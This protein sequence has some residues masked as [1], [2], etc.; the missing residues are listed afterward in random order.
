MD[1]IHS[2]INTEAQRW[3]SVSR[4]LQLTC[5]LALP[6]L[7]QAQFNFTTNDDGTATITGYTGSGGTVTIPATLNGLSV[8]GIGDGALATC[9]SLTNLTI[10]N[11]ITRIGDGAFASCTNLASVTIPDSVTSIGGEAFTACL[12]LTSVAIPNSVTNIGDWA[13]TDCTALTAID[14]DP[15]NPVYSSIAGVLFDQ[16]QDTLVSYPGGLPGS[17]AI[18]NSVTSIQKYAF[19]TCT[20]LS[21]VTIPDSVTNVGDYAFYICTSLAGLTLPSSLTSIGN[22]TFGHCTSL[23]NVAIPNSVT[24]LGNYAFEYCISL[25]SVAIPSSTT[26]LGGNLFMGCTSLTEIDVDPSNPT[27][28]SFAGVLFDKG[29]TTLIEYPGGQAGSYTIPNGVASIGPGA[30]SDCTNLTSVTI[31]ESVTTIGDDA[32]EYCF[33]LTSLAIPDLLTNLGDYAFA[34]CDSLT[35]STM[36]NSVASIGE[37]AFYD[38]TNLASVIIPSSVISLGGS[39]FEGCDDLMAVFFQGNA[40]TPENDSTVF[41]SDATNLAAYYL[42]GTTGWGLIFDDLP[43]V[44]LTES[45]TVNTTT[46]TTPLLV[47]FQASGVDSAGNAITNWSW[48]FGDGAS[49]SAPNPAHTYTTAGTFSPAL[50][51]TNNLGLMVLG[52]GTQITTLA[53][54]ASTDFIYTTNNGAITITGYTGPGGSVLIPSTIDDLTVTSIGASAFYDSALLLSVTIPDSVTNIADG[55]FFECESLTNVTIG[56]GVISLGDEAFGGCTGLTNVTIPT[57]IVSIG[58]EAFEDCLGLTSVTIPNSV[59]NVGETPFYNCTSLIEID[60]D[61]G[62]PVYVSIAGVLLDQ[63]QTTLLEYPSGQVGSYTIPSTV[64]CIGDQA[65]EGCT[66]LTNVTFP[67]GVTT[68]GNYSFAYCSNLTSVVFPPTS[69]TNLGNYA[70]AYCT[71]LKSLDLPASLTT[72]NTVATNSGGGRLGDYDFAYCSGLDAIYYPGDPPSSETIFADDNAVVY[73]PAA[74]A[75]WGAELFGMPTVELNPPAVPAAVYFIRADGMS[76]QINVSDLLT[77][78]TLAQGDAISLVGAGTDGLNRLS[79]NGTTLTINDTYLLYTN[80]VIPD[81][82]DSFNFTVSDALGQTAV[83]TVLIVMDRNVIGQASPN[84][85][86]TPSNVIANFSGVPTFP[87]TVERSTNLMQGAGWVAICTNP[88]STNGLFQ[89]LDRFQDLSNSVPL[90]PASAYY[91]LRYNP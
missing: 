49:S 56:H 43:A 1:G 80:S 65:F 14:V 59:T 31:S 18:P 89:V 46:G 44:M 78:V 8:T 66:T 6:A 10:S 71:S 51:A 75:G 33:G 42:A 36:G 34:Y 85:T 4:L 74:A 41:Q 28:S 20:T 50:I 16:A 26:T 27:Y 53:P 81:V 37:Y 79:T 55:A 91:R 72:A 88:A 12:S 23:T 90:I 35:N 64:I 57:N 47:S 73:Y 54:P 87:Y 76:L 24:S 11:G 5:L 61:P 52:V 69:L 48:N 32:F 13:F 83:G 2:V 22:G 62:N 40:P 29:Q 7:A 63:S 19:Y 84:L 15:E 86:I 17:Y 39:A 38:C 25:A 30:F 58:N 21:N 9:L 70:F 82:N 3:R 45:F 60:V 67:Q 77:N 68:I